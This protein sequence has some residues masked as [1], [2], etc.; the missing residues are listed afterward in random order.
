MRPVFAG[1]TFHKPASRREWIERLV[2]LA[3]PCRPHIG[4]DLNEI[5]DRVDA[6][7]WHR[8]RQLL[9]TYSISRLYELRDYTTHYFASAALV[10]AVT[11]MQLA[12]L[13]RKSVV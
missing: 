10:A 8:F 12:G 11:A 13:D 4:G 2:Y 9:S 6:Q 3:T 1:A 5:A 7:D